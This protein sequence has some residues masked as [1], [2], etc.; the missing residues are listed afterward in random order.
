MDTK[1]QYNQSIHEKIKSNLKKFT[2]TEKLIAE[3]VIRHDKDIAFFS[4]QDMSEKLSI[5][6]AS[7]LR[8]TNKL[9]YDGW[10]SFKKVIIFELKNVI[11]PVEKYKINFQ[12]SDDIFFAYNQIAQNEVENIN[13]SINNLDRAE[14]DK[15][16]K[17]ILNADI[18]YVAGMSMSSHL[19]GILSYLLQRIGINSFTINNYSTIMAEQL[20]N[21]RKKDLLIAFSLPDYSKETIEAAKF[22]VKR[23]KV[24]TITNSVTSPITE[25]SNANLIVKTDS[26]YFSNSLTPILVFIYGFIK[27]I[28]ARNK[29]KSQTAIDKIISIR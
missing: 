11:T 7:I 24:I 10:A 9:G 16:I 25:F 27:E 19:A 5:G 23:G 29:N 26:L 2:K 3:Y 4:I 1:T 28:V 6:P 15:S 21:I 12:N 14:I 13:Y 20:I 18:V 17:L 22:A 8:F